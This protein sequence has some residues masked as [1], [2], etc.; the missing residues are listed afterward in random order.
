M[1]MGIYSFI[2][3]PDV[4]AHCRAIGKTWNTYEMAVII[5]RSNRT[6]EDRHE[7]WREG[8]TL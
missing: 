2:R 6:R 4:A 8:N 7:A 1:D 5:G 3:S